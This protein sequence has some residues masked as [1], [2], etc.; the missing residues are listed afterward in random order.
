[1]LGVFRVSSVLC[2][3]VFLVLCALLNLILGQMCLL[4]SL[5][6]W[7]PDFYQHFWSPCLSCSPYLFFVLPEDRD[8]RRVSAYVHTHTKSVNDTVLL[9]M[10]WTRSQ[11]ASHFVDSAY[12]SCQTHNLAWWSKTVCIFVV[13]IEQLHF[14]LLVSDCWKHCC[15]LG[16]GL[17]IF[18][19]RVA[20][21]IFILVIFNL[22]SVSVPSLC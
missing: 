16:L 9:C 12:Q 18:Q 21:S 11:T 13:Y 19:F 2:F 6:L 17:G 5:L 8:I 1:M 14:C 10:T 7:A 15:G 3:L 4:T 22:V 20:I